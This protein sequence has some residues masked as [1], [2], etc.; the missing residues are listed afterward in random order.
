MKLRIERPT[1]TFI[2]AVMFS[3]L[4]VA[5]LAAC[6]EADSPDSATDQ[7]TPQRDAASVSGSEPNQDTSRTGEPTEE[8]TEETSGIIPRLGG[9][10][11][12][13]SDDG[14]TGFASVS[15]GAE[16]TCGVRTDRSVACWGEQVRGLMAPGARP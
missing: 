9:N 4:L 11:D 16:H 1:T 12:G 10:K 3:A 6:G 13:N 8:V 2:L 5:A 7:D 14:K 15:A